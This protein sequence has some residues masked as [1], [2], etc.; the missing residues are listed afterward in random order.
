MVSAVVAYAD[1]LPLDDRC[2]D[3]GYGGA[4]GD[5]FTGKHFRR[6]LEACVRALSLSGVEDILV[7]NYGN[8]WYPRIEVAGARMINR[9]DKAAFSEWDAKWLGI[10]QAKYDHVVTT[11]ADILVNADVVRWF[12]RKARHCHYCLF[13]GTKGWLNER[14]TLHFLRTGE[15][16]ACTHEVIVDIREH[17]EMPIDGVEPVAWADR[18]V[19]SRVYM[20]RLGLDLWKH[21]GD[22]QA[23]HRGLLEQV[24]YPRGAKGWGWGDI[25]FRLRAR[26]AG[27]SETWNRT[28][29]VWHMFHPCQ[30]W[31]V[32]GEECAANMRKWGRELDWSAG[33]SRWVLPPLED[34]ETALHSSARYC[35][36]RGVG[37]AE[38]A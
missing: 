18:R 16:N 2:S 30:P 23:F 37:D 20:E 1:R 27:I 4:R 8:A 36:L 38:K 11:N 34:R 29:P 13:Q 15:L 24:A 5:C 19:A 17:S 14:Q 33:G 3:H 21:S 25:E 28:H 31:S 26:E 7:V 22:F 12:L 35:C 10:Q 32:R 6:L 9:P